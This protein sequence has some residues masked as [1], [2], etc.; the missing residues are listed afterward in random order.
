MRWVTISNEEV[1]TINIRVGKFKVVH[2][3]CCCSRRICTIWNC[4]W[5]RV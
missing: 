5:H 1:G 2:A 4:L 3:Y